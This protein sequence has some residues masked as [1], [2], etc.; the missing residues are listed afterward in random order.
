MR[1][2]SINKVL[3]NHWS[4]ENI[5]DASEAAAKRITI[6]NSGTAVPQSAPQ[7][8]FLHF[9]KTFFEYLWARDEHVGA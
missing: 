6:L 1:L 4:R 3:L 7:W 2:A 8:K 9:H 5:R